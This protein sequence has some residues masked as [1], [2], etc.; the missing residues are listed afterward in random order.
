MDEYAKV[1]EY[2]WSPQFPVF[3]IQHRMGRDGE[4]KKPFGKYGD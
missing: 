1:V 2:F 4:E 3:E